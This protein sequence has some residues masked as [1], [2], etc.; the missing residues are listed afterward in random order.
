MEKIKR[1]STLQKGEQ[2]ESIQLP[3]GI[4]S[5]GCC[6]C[7]IYTDLA[8]A[9]DKVPLKRLLHKLKAYGIRGEL[10]NW[11]KAWLTGQ[12]GVGVEGCQ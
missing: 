5:S 10:L 2:A 4:R 9:F 12:Q 3:T 7:H 1:Y 8:K 6:G 11:I